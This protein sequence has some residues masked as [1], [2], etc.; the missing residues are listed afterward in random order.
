M[1][2]ITHYVKDDTARFNTTTKES[3]GGSDT[4]TDTIANN[5]KGDTARLNPTLEIL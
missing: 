5:V 3:S 1:D 4:T 2:T